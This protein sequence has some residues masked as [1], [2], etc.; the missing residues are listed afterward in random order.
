LDETRGRGRE[1]WWSLEELPKAI[2][3]INRSDIGDSSGACRETLTLS[4]RTGDTISRK[5]L[6]F[7]QKTLRCFLVGGGGGGRF[8]LLR[9]EH[10]LGKK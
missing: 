6:M 7:R 9:S 10:Q 2:Q 8:R 3:G 5:K 4:E 1:L